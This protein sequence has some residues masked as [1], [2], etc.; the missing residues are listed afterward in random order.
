[1]SD[2]TRADDWAEILEQMDALAREDVT[3]KTRRDI[4]SRLLMLGTRA[5]ICAVRDALRVLADP[6]SEERAMYRA[7]HLVRLA[8]MRTRGVSSG[9]TMPAEIPPTTGQRVP[10]S[11]SR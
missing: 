1:M 3:P 4:E 5:R 6:T 8:G 9:D 10:R 11:E 7:T 2:E